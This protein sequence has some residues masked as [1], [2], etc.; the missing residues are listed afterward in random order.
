MSG[1]ADGTPKSCRGEVFAPLV[2]DRARA[3][4]SAASDAT[5]AAKTPYTSIFLEPATGGDRSDRP[6]SHCEDPDH[7]FSNPSDKMEIGFIGHAYRR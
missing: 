5:S 6:L 4:S 3:P 7:D 1:V 2:R